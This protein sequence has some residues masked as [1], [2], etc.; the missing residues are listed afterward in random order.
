MA[1]SRLLAISPLF[2]DP[3]D[4]ADLREGYDQLGM[5]Y[6]AQFHALDAVKMQATLMPNLPLTWSIPS[7]DGFGG[8]ITPSRYYS[9]YSTLLQP[10]DALPAVDGRLGERLTLRSC[11][12]A[13]IPPRRWL[14]ATD[15]R[16]V[17]TDKVFDFWQDGVFYDTALWSFWEGVTE[18]DLS[19]D[20]RF[21]QAGVVHRQPLDSAAPFIPVQEGFMLTVTDLA[22]LPDI[23]RQQPGI[24]AVTA[25]DSGEPGSFLEIQPPPFERV[26]SGAVKVFRSPPSGKR[27]YLAVDARIV[28]DDA[29]GDQEAL[30]LLRAGGSDVIHG[31]AA[32]LSPPPDDSGRVDILDYAETRVSLEVSAPQAAF[33]VFSD[34]WYPGWR[35]TVNG[36]PAPIQR[37]NLV[38]R[39]LPVPAGDSRV[40]FSFEPRL[41]RAALYI[42]CA[43]W[44]ITLLVALKPSV[45]NTAISRIRSRQPLGGSENGSLVY[46]EYQSPSATADGGLIKKRRNQT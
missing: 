33:L 19:L 22:S 7:I 12:A 25:I 46:A 37:A 44:L 11:R 13:C 35:A 27:A 3:L 2:F 6:A 1:P 23:L 36:A 5:D 24:V 9:L 41:W 34:A 8:G 17:I 26:F 30:Q 28:A 43:L 42:G 4:I 20:D 14:A 40:V 16:T 31:A 38:F 21:D 45:L 32:A 39:A 18:L 10:P 29:A 15:T